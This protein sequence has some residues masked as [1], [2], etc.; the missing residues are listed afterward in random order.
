MGLVQPKFAAAMLAGSL[1]ALLGKFDEA[2]GLGIRTAI[3]M[4]ANVEAE[5]PKFL[6]HLRGDHG[7]HRAGIHLASDLGAQVIDDFEP[8]IAALEAPAHGG[9]GRVAVAI[10]EEFWKPVTEEVVEFLPHAMA[11]MHWCPASGRLL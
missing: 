3:E 4:V 5:V 9:F 8:T 6:F 10:A 1:R 2:M 11:I 7:G